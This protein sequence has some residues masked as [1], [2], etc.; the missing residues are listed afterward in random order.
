MMAHIADF[1]KITRDIGVQIYAGQGGHTGNIVG[2]E[3]SR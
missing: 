1:V 3:R 2:A